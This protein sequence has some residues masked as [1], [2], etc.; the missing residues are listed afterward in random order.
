MGMGMGETFFSSIEAERA[1]PELNAD[2]IEEILK[3][4]EELWLTDE[5]VRKVI[6]EDDWLKFIESVK[7]VLK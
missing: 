5:E 6:S 4:L 7:Q 2:D 1:L 3:W